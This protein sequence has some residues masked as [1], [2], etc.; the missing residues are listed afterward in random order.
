M[1]CNACSGIDVKEADVLQ[2]LPCCCTQS[3]L[4]ICGNNSCVYHQRDILVRGRITDDRLG[5]NE[6]CPCRDERVQVK[7]QCCGPYRQG[8]SIDDRGEQV[9]SMTEYVCGDEHS[10]L[11]IRVEKLVTIL[12]EC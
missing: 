4:H 7:V 8:P 11:G 3:I 2:Q 1:V 6:V 10:G 5:F 12:A 9:T